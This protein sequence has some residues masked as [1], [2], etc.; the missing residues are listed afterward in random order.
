MAHRI[1]AVSDV[2]QLSSHHSPPASTSYLQPAARCTC[3]CWPQQHSK[4]NR[5]HH[6]TRVIDV[7]GLKTIEYHLMT[8]IP[9]TR[10]SCSDRHLVD[11]NGIYDNS[12]MVKIIDCWKNQERHPSLARLYHIRTIFWDQCQKVETLVNSI[13]I[14]NLLNH[15]NCYKHIINI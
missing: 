6:S 14:Y 13:T 5:G 7:Q 2:L 9:Y 4:R 8:F 3:W 11:I 1:S 12:W 10:T 15:I